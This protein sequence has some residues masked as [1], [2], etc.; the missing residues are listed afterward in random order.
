MTAENSGTQPK[1]ESHDPDFP[2]AFLSFMR[3]GWREDPLTV[4]PRP[5]VPNYAKRRAALSEAFPGETLVIPSGNE[6]VRANDTDYHF[7]PGSDFF[8]LTGDHDPD[9]VLILHPSGSGHD[10]VLYTRQRNSKDT[11]RFFR[12]RNGELWVGR[13]HTLAE[14]STELGLPTAA[15]GDLGP[16]LAGAAPG[17][18]RVLRG[19]DPHVDRAVL[20][21]EP[22]RAKLRDRELAHVI[23]ELK[24]VKDEWE[25]AQLQAAIDATVRGFEDVARV[26]PADRGVRE[27]LLEG[28]FGLRARHDGNDVGYT[29][30]VGAGPHATILHWV[31]NTGVTV[32]GELL[33]MDMGV[34]GHNLYTADV[35][36]T[37][38][39]N[40]VFT[41]LQRQVYDIVHASQQAG[42]DAIKPGV[43]FRDVHKVCMRVLAEGLHDLGL[44]PVGVDQAMADDSTIYRRWTLHGFG[45]ML[46]IDVHDCS[47]ARNETYREGELK[48]GYVLTVEPGLYFQPEDE[49][50][51]EELRGVGVR[52]EDD[53][54]VTAD[55]CRNLSAGLPRS[56]GEVEQWLAAQREAGPRLPG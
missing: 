47:A 24:L 14:K 32:P 17:R 10:A 4:T 7:R 38:P 41:P 40:G 8:Y 19:L 45:H 3:Q 50:V 21:Y 44:L 33:L 1:T 15:L 54:L 25:I 34:E 26:L 12:D 23:S 2:E 36:R 9:S 6:K 5:E 29:S 30:I 22:D 53:V 56:S 18:T 35:T 39:V 20:P 42:M 48:E 49:L 16:A 43:V 55:G 27:R 31:R 51:P 37:V 28:V 52:I 46:G 13:T 11:D